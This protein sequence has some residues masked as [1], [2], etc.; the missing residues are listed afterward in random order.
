MSPEMLFNCL[1]TLVAKAYKHSLNGRIFFL[2]MADVTPLRGS[3]LEANLEDILEILRP[4]KA[5]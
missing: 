5:L 1:L 2:Q 3:V 4:L